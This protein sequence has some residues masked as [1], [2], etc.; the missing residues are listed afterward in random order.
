MVSA[1][2]PEFADHTR[3]TTC[4]WPRG[5]LPVTVAAMDTGA[6]VVDVAAV[7]YTGAM[8]VEDTGAMV[9]D[10]AAVM[11]TGEM[12]RRRRGSWNRRWHQGGKRDGV[13]NR[14]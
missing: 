13:S 8:V 2:L 3:F 5:Y 4:S 9:M 10:T 7:M 14:Y 11:D 6:M 12:T 1:A